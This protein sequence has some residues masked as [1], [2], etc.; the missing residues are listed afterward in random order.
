MLNKVKRQ[1]IPMLETLGEGIPHYISQDDTAEDKM[2]VLITE[3]LDA[4]DSSLA[5]E[6]GFIKEAKSSLLHALKAKDPEAAEQCFSIYCMEINQIPV[7]YKCVFFPYYQNTWDSL[8]SVYQAFQEDSRFIAEIVII[9]IRRNTQTGSKII[10]DNYLTPQGIPN[11]PYYQYHIDEDLPDFVF[12]NNPYDGVNVEQFQSQNIKPYAGCMIYIPYYLYWHELQRKEWIQNL[13]ERATELP[14]HDSCDIFVAQGSSFVKMFRHRSKNGRKMVALGNPKTDYIFN[15]RERF[16]KYPEWEKILHGRTVL[17]L[18]THY[19]LAVNRLL[20][21][22]W[23]YYLLKCIVAADEDLALIWRPHPQSFLLGH[24]NNDVV[25]DYNW[26]VCLKVAEE[27]DRIIIDR[28]ESA[29][30]AMMYS[31]AVISSRSSIVAEAVFMDKP[32]YFTDIDWREGLPPDRVEEAF[33]EAYF[34]A[35]QK[36]REY[37]IQNLYLLSA[38]HYSGLD[39]TPRKDRQAHYDTQLPPTDFAIDK[40]VWK[41]TLGDFVHDI[42]NGVD[43]KKELRKVFR[44][45]LFANREGNCGQAV[46]NYVASLL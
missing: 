31:D 19:T 11:T 8:E 28:T 23:V 44:E 15:R 30:S 29:L 2:L 9:P 5:A 21:P 24:S 39:E 43:R 20:W 25:D 37:D 38:V 7:Q 45:Q 12:Y 42:K 27:C 6:A 16:Q 10:Y 1:L 18:N 32:V 4:I 40:Y 46:L 36:H 34:R 26:E 41:L 17:F 13:V 35:I 22:R 3:F 33:S 14:G